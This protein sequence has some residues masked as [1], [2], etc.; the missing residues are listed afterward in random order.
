MVDRNVSGSWHSHI[1]TVKR[2]LYLGGGVFGGPFMYNSRFINAELSP[3][4]SADEHV[5]V[6]YRTTEVMLNT[7]LAYE[8]QHVTDGVKAA[9]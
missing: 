3:E 4:A 7:L 5:Q 2:N 6:M 8:R 9:A 1:E